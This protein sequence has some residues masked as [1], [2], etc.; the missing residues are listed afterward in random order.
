M[1]LRCYQIHP[2]DYASIVDEIL[3]NKSQIPVRAAEYY[4]ETPKQKLKARVRD[5]IFLLLS[6]KKN[7]QDDE[8]RYSSFFNLVFLYINL[9]I[10]ILSYNLKA[11][12][13]FF[14]K[15]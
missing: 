5:Q 10:L 13:F 1:I 3:D 14:P 4:S 12:M 2:G 15:E 6:K 8:I 7:I 9:K 11:K